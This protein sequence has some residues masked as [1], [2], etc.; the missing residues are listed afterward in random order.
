MPR[1]CWIGL[2][3]VMLSIFL[4]DCL[5]LDE[6][7]EA[8]HVVNMMWHDSRSMGKSDRGECRRSRHLRTGNGS[9]KPTTS[10]S[11]GTWVSDGLLIICF[12]YAGLLNRLQWKPLRWFILTTSRRRHGGDAARRPPENARRPLASAQW[13]SGD[14]AQRPS[15]NTRRGHRGEGAQGGGMSARCGAGRRR[16]GREE[17]HHSPPPGERSGRGS[18]LGLGFLPKKLIYTV[19]CLNYRLNSEICRGVFATSRNSNL[20]LHPTATIWVARPIGWWF[21]FPSYGCNKP[22][23]S[24]RTCLLLQA[25][26]CPAPSSYQGQKTTA[27]T[28][29]L[30]RLFPSAALKEPVIALVL[31]VRLFK[32]LEALARRHQ[33]FRLVAVPRWAAVPILVVGHGRSYLGTW[34]Y[35]GTP[36][37]FNKNS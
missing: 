2:D 16:A 25:Q 18:H 9:T 7:C 36:I 30:Q 27:A 28:L 35:K 29:I 3:S 6:R 34:V 15:E 17:A 11:F 14:A 21:Y 33:C 13:D 20:Q 19:V 24:P 12:F 4:S 10:A 1:D 8:L 32:A 26:T 37:I 23:T 22:H 5:V 31:C